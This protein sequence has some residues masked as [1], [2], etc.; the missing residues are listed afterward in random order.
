M[1]Q[2]LKKWQRDIPYKANF[3]AQLPVIVNQNVQ[4]TESII[5]ERDNIWKTDISKILRI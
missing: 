5:Y 1:A 3:M 4:D 2:F